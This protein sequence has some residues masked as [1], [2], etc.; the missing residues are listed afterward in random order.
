MLKK[1]FLVALFFVLSMAEETT[2]KPDLKIG[3]N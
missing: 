3:D 2:I 1:F